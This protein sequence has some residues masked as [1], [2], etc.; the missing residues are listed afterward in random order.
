MESTTDVLE[1]SEVIELIKK[2]YYSCED[3][4]YHYPSA[5]K[6]IV[7]E[8]EDDI[9][10]I[11]R[12]GEID[13]DDVHSFRGYLDDVEKI[14][15]RYSEKKLIYHTTSARNAFSILT[16]GYWLPSRYES[17]H[18]VGIWWKG[19]GY[20]GFMKLCFDREKERLEKIKNNIDEKRKC[21]I[22]IKVL[23]KLMYEIEPKTFF[24]KNLS[25]YFKNAEINQVMF[26][27]DPT[28]I[29]LKKMVF[30]EEN[31]ED[32]IIYYCFNEKDNETIEHLKQLDVKKRE[33]E[34]YY[35]YEPVS[36]NH[37]RYII[38]QDLCDVKYIIEQD[39]GKFYTLISN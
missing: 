1:L 17:L 11:P 35:T 7:N 2:H 5:L 12:N 22:R 34:N 15:E 24:S 25:T 20:N 37:I 9:F 32:D 33:L 4:F 21:E 10:L 18:H 16:G 31:I 26:A 13:K 39:D 19:H 27:I 3:S 8:D 29:D 38:L 36:I 6:I 14:I 28:G 30:Y 23:E